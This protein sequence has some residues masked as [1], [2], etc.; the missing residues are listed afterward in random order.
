MLEVQPSVLREGQGNVRVVR[1]STTKDML[2]MDSVSRST[3]A[4]IKLVHI[5]QILPIQ[6]RPPTCCL[7]TLDAAATSKAPMGRCCMS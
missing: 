2:A 6:A 4:T 1:E 7:S 3:L 5:P